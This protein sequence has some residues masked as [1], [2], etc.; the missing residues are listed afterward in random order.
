M[1][2]SAMLSLRGDAHKFYLRLK[3]SKK[4]QAIDECKELAEI[5]E[6]QT[7]YTEMDSRTLNKIQYRMVKEK[8]GSGIIPIFISAGPWL[9]FIFSKQL[10]RFLFKEGSLLWIGFVLV[11][12]TTLTVSVI[13]HFREKA[14]ASVHIEIIQDIL[15]ER[16]IGKSVDQSLG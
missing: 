9:L 13:V 5:E 1:E 4:Q 11:Y 15:R 2:V 12:M 14:W 8:N 3:R 10:Q 16:G 7:F 6:I